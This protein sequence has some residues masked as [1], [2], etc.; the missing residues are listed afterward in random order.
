MERK[1]KFSQK[2]LRVVYRGVVACLALLGLGVVI[3]GYNVKQN[4]ASKADRNAYDS[5]M[6]AGNGSKAVELAKRIERRGSFGADRADHMLAQAY[7]MNGDYDRAAEFLTRCGGEYCDD[8]ARL[9]YKS[10]QKREAFDAWTAKAKKIVSSCYPNSRWSLKTRNETGVGTFDELE[11]DDKTTL[12]A[13]FRR[14]ATMEKTS[15]PKL[16]PFATYADFLAFMEAE[17]AALPESDQAERSAAMDFIR[18]VATDSKVESKFL[19]L[20]R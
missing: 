13:S 3:V 10:G 19:I 12:R 1:D 9:D 11:A 4:L 17:F 6:R 7:E 8:W 20:E 14:A 18:S 15:Y 16:S 2:T 5:A